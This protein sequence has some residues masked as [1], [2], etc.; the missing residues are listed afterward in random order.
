MFFLCSYNKRSI[1][2]Q[3]YKIRKFFEADLY[4]RRKTNVFILET[5]RKFY[6]F[7]AVAMAT[8]YMKPSDHLKNLTGRQR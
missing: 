7:S 3:W 2:F 5:E 6:D 4:G 8:T 1:V